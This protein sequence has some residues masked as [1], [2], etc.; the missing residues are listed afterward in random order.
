MTKDGVSLPRKVVSSFG[1]YPEAKPVF[2]AG[3]G[4][5]SVKI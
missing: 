1:F 4:L 3:I 2:A 5:T